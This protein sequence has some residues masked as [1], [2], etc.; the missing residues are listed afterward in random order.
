M[1]VV[2]AL[3]AAL[4]ARLA[5]SLLD[6]LSF[7]ITNRIMLLHRRALARCQVDLPKQNA[8][9]AVKI[10]CGCRRSVLQVL[11]FYG[12]ILADRNAIDQLEHNG[13]AVEAGNVEVAAMFLHHLS[14][15]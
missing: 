7:R 3:S 8:G 11:H 13:R 9:F 4:A 5:F 15:S 6:P 1:T 2:P 10:A 12:R 14:T